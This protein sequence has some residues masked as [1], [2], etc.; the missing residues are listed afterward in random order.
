MDEESSISTIAAGGDS[1]SGTLSNWNQNNAAP[2]RSADELCKDLVYS[3][4]KQGGVRRLSS[5]GPYQSLP[6]APRIPLELS[7]MVP[8]CLNDLDTSGMNK[9]G[10][11][12]LWAGPSMRVNS[13][14][15][16][17]TIGRNVRV[18]EDASLHCVW[19]EDILYLK[20]L[21]LYLCS[22]AFWE[23][24]LDPAND[25][26]SP[27]ERDRLRATSLG[28]LRSYAKLIQRRSDFEIARKHNLL[29]SF[30]NIGFDEFVR[31]IMSFDLQ[32]DNAVSIRWQMGELNLD[33]LNFYSVILLHHWH[34]HRYES[35]Y[36]AYFQ[37]FFPVVLF[38]FALFS[39]TLSAMQ[40]ILGAQS[41]KETDNKGLK[42]T[43]G[44]FIWFGTEA[45]G[46][47]IAFAAVFVIWWIVIS[48]NEAWKRRRLQKGWK[49][50]NADRAATLPAG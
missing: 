41:L 44:L 35:R 4:H 42:R 38:M 23:C 26:I 13:L 32:P 21:P 2:F 27:E 29:G 7:L 28:F 49:R 1:Q 6:D 3:E 8:Y 15:K 33:A 30:D 34:L 19:S 36:G 17:L 22:T 16:Q 31:F 12:L 18:S 43:I 24:I 46:W 39:V 48:S 50:Q 9:L 5:C 45:I 47:S 14:S 10:Q 20:P 11:K 25:G 40:V 37:R